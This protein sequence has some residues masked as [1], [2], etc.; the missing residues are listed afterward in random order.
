MHPSTHVS[1]LNFVF[2]R[3]HLTHHCFEREIVGKMH[4]WESRNLELTTGLKGKSIWSCS[5]RSDS[6]G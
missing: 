3:L 1:F 2:S 4:D 5:C 6:D